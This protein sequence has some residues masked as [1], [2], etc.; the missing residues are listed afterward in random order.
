M[1]YEYFELLRLSDKLVYQFDRKTMPDGSIAYQRRDQDL[2]IVYNTD[3]GWIAWNDDDQSISGRPWAVMIQDQNPDHPPE[4]EW[5][6]KKNEK[7][8]VYR[9]IYKEIPQWLT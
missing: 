6:S 5:V 1:T 4:G 2:W 3:F 7:S 9:L 8:Y